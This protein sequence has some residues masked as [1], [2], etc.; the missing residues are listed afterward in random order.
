[1]WA[2]G[3]WV[4]TPCSVARHITYLSSHLCLH[5]CRVGISELLAT[6]RLFVCYA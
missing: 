6:E 3:G 4:R 5:V 2:F 1:M